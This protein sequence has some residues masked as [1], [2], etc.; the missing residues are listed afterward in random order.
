MTFI[1]E[2]TGESSTVNVTI[3]PLTGS[4]TYTGTGEQNNYPTVGVFSF[5]DQSGTLFFDFSVDG[6]NWHT[7]PTLGFNCAANIPEFH[8]AVKLGRFFRVRYVNDGDAQATFRLSSYFGY[9]FLPSNAPIGFTIA[10]DADAIVVKAVISGVGDL[11]ARVTEHQALQVSPPPEGRSSFGEFLT[12]EITPVIEMSFHTFINPITISSRANQS[13]AVTNADS[14]AVCSTGAAANSSAAIL[15]NETVRFKAGQGVRARFD[16][17]FMTGA[18]NS[19]QFAGIGDEGNA[20][21]FGYN[22]T[23][24]GLLSRTGGVREL[25]TLTVTTKSTTAENIT[26]TLDSDATA[27][28]AV[29]DATATDVTTTA[30]EIAAHDYSDVGRGWDARAVGATVIFTSWNDEPRAG[31]YS[32]SSA[33][34]AVGSFAQTIVGVSP[35]DAW[36]AQD[37]WVGDDKFDG[38]GN[39]KATLNPTKGNVY[40][41]D[42]Q[43]GFGAVNFFI[44]SPVDG[45]FH[46]VHTIAYGNANTVPGIVRPTL[47]LRISAENFANTSNII[48]KTSSMAAFVDG[49][50]EYTGTRSGTKSTIAGATGG[51]PVLTLRCNEVFNSK[52]NHGELKISIVGAS[53]EASGNN[54]VSIDFYA[55][56]TLT[57]ASFGNVNAGFSQAQVDTTATAATGGIFLFSID[58]GKAGN[59]L[60][61]LKDDKH[62]GIVTPGNAITA[63][64][65]P[66]GGNSAAAVTFNFVD[67]F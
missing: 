28:V 38:T 45:E 36:T 29:T 50:D 62:A 33:S 48:V 67:L 65:R 63:V 25:R 14:M 35:T 20:Y 31:T 58:L 34:T 1:P 26:I 15:S 21:A 17:L 7:F 49:K 3:T 46:K 23:A 11:N 44:E 18:A 42:Y 64:I 40:Q 56:M 13:G 47:G 12:I 51:E 10:D 6:T 43:M 24:F 2:Q 22:G 54:T 16:A 41:I 8:T 27:T 61:N 55:G 32:L 39:S 9:N 19:I 59:G 66:S 30:N 37:D 4:A 57:G 60:I 52:H 5:A 53:V